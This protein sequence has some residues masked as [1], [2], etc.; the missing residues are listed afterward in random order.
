MLVDTNVLVRVLARDDAE[1]AAAADAA[2]AQTQ[3]QAK[4]FWAVRENQ[5]GGQKAEG[6]AWK[7]DISVPVSRIADFIQQATVYNVEKFFGW[8]ATVNDFCGAI[9]QAAPADAA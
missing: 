6:A 4:A 3:V 5:S 2:I 8:V 7:H 1:Q 9:G